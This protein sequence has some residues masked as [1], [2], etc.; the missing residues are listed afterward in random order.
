MR[1][2]IISKACEL[3]IRLGFNS[4]TMDDL[5]SELCISKKTLYKFFSNKEVLVQEATY[6]LEKQF[7]DKINQ[8]MSLNYNS[9][10][11]HF[12]IRRLFKGLVKTVGALP[13]YQ[14]KKKYPDIYKYVISSEHKM[15]NLFM[16]RN[17]A[18]GIEQGYYRSDV[19]IEEYISFYYTIR[20]HINENVIDTIQVDR[21]ELSALVYHIQAISTEKGRNELNRQLSINA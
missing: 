17:L 12:E 13:L 16:R 14:L 20:F 9:V 1:K 10:E 11:E 2:K 7:Y 8:V 4:V 18:R 5:A 6:I 19:E 3:F 21:L 15:F